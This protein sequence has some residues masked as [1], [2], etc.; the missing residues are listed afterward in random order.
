MIPVRTLLLGWSLAL[1]SILAAPS[2]AAA[3]QSS[4]PKPPT[5]AETEAWIVGFLTA[6]GSVSATLTT[7]QSTAER[8]LSIGTPSFMGCNLTY[9]AEDDRTLESDREGDTRPKHQHF[10]TTQHL[11]FGQAALNSA[12][13]VPLKVY[14]ADDE[15][16]VLSVHVANVTDQLLAVFFIDSQDSASRLI[17]ALNAEIQFCGGRASPY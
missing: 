16:P 10:S 8:T 9:T 11:D 3:Q 6:H 17:K 7:D 5:Q 1:V 4:G 15:L 2:F 14:G 12:K 13:V